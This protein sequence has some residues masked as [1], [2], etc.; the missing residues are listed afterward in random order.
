[1]A[2]VTI[3]QLNS[4]TGYGDRGKQRA[5]NPDRERDR[6]AFDRS[7][8]YGKQ[9]HLNDKRCDVR[10]DNGAKCTLITEHNCGD[11]LGTVAQLFSY[12]LTNQDVG[13]N[14]DPDG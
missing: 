13:V 4:T 9:N 1:M 5:D 7:A 11:G 14:R 10:I 2:T 6:K 12:P 8:T 3:D